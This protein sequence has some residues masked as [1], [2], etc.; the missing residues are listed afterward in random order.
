MKYY[1]AIPTYNGGEIWRAAVANIQ[2]YAPANLFVHV[3]DSTSKDDTVAIAEKA[4][5]DVLTIAGSDFNHGGTRNQAVEKYIENYDVVIFLTQ[6]AIPRQ[7]FIEEIISVLLMRVL[8]APMGG[9]YLI[10]MLIHLHDTL[11][12]LVIRKKDM[13]VGKKIFQKWD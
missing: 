8:H 4:G 5:F 7:N 13:F 3:I 2:K 11:E 9:S 10:K 6:D 12:D 1:I